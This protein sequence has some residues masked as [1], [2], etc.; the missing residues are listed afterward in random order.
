MRN[1]DAD[2]GIPEFKSSNQKGNTDNTSTNSM[3]LR[4]RQDAILQE[5]RTD[6]NRGEYGSVSIHADLKL[7]NM[8]AVKKMS[9]TK[10]ITKM[11]Q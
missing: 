1:S 4:Y 3:P 8:S 6:L 5:Y 2:P 10:S 11:P 9:M 7:T